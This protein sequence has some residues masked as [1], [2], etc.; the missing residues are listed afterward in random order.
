MTS[1]LFLVLALTA[2]SSEKPKED[3]SLIRQDIT[4]KAKNAGGPPVRAIPPAPGPLMREVV[5]SLELFRKE[6]GSEPAPVKLDA[7]RRRLEQPFPG[8]PFLAFKPREDSPAYDRWT[9]EVLSGSEVIWRHSGYEP[10]SEPLEWDGTGFSVA[11][12]ARAGKSYRFRFTASSRGEEYVLHSESIELKSLTY[13]ELTGERR[14][15]VSN[16]LL[17]VRGQENFGLDSDRYLAEMGDRM[18][19]S[20]MG[21]SPYKLI[22]YQKKPDSRLAKARAFSLARYFSKYLVVSPSRIL[23]SLESER[24]RGDS[25]ACLLPPEPPGQQP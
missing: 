15:E 16:S 18:R 1:K 23:V 12:A 5:E 14:L 6:Q 8:P 3:A 4:I 9:F 2:A 11:M 21:E 7:T 13:R 22:L 19:R 20:P 24:G 17:F 10:L 25:T